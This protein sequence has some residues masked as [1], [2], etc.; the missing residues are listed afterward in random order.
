MHLHRLEHGSA[1]LWPHTELV[2]VTALHSCQKFARQLCL[3]YF[4]R[5][6][7]YGRLRLSKQKRISFGAC[8][9]CEL[10]LRKTFGRQLLEALRVV[11]G[12]PCLFLNTDL[13]LWR[14]CQ[15]LG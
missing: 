1:A 11:L 5:V 6:D 12:L 2:L 3:R 9:I 4:F 7:G 13:R 15:S 10:R 8:V 14:R